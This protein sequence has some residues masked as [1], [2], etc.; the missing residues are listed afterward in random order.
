MRHM[1][2]HTALALAL[3]WC[4]AG[5][6]QAPAGSSGPGK[7]ASEGNQANPG[8]TQ[9]NTSRRGKQVRGGASASGQ[10]RQGK[11]S[12]CQPVGSESIQTVMRKMELAKQSNDPAN[13]RRAIDDTQMLLSQLV[14]YMEN[15]AGQK[16]AHEQQMNESPGGFIPRSQSGGTPGQQGHGGSRGSMAPPEN[17]GRGEGDWPHS[18]QPQAPPPDKR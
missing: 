8:A 16:S 2:A 1:A 6:A 3:A 18:G 9:G 14:D 12:S 13:M 5:W 7:T 4:T 11:S 15:C 10:R 17:S